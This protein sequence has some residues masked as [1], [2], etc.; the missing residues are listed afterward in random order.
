MIKISVIIP[1]FNEEKNIEQ[2]L[3]SL[4]VQKI[5]KGK[6]IKND[7]F[8]IIVVDNNSNDKTREVVEKFKKE[9][10]KLNLFLVSEKEK[11]IIPA[12]RKGFRYAL[13]KN[14]NIRTLFLAGTDADVIVNEK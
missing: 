4:S 8:E 14:K 9:H 5:D 12:R 3:Q 13:E 10:P 11:G 6:K 2:T 7:L 1:T